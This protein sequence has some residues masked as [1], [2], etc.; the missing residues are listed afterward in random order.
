MGGA[1]RLW[2][3]ENQPAGVGA[4]SFH[5]GGGTAEAEMETREEQVGKQ[6]AVSR[7]DVGDQAGRECRGSLGVVIGRDTVGE[8]QCCARGGCPLGWEVSHWQWR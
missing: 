8:C 5:E 3:N 6:A 7:A 2:G 1:L 4:E